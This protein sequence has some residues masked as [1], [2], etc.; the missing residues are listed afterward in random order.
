[1]KNENR[2]RI[3]IRI[4]F[5]SLLYRVDDRPIF[6][7]RDVFSL[8]TAIIRNDNAARK[9]N[10]IYMVPS[11]ASNHRSR[12]MMRARST[13]FVFRQFTEETKRNDFQ[14]RC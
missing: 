5:I 9:K 10:T 7:T 14:D 12:I 4:L 6:Y 11:K 2:N 8:Y 13:A 1:M 3:D